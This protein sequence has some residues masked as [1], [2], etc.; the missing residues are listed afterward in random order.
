MCSILYLCCLENFSNVNNQCNQVYSLYKWSNPH[1]MI[2]WCRQSNF[3]CVILCLMELDLPEVVFS[4]RT[5]IKA[6]YNPHQ[7][8]TQCYTQTIPPS[9][10]CHIWSFLSTLNT[11]EQK[12]NVLIMWTPPLP[13]LSSTLSSWPE[14][15]SLLINSQRPPFEAQLPCLTA[16]LRHSLRGKW[17]YKK[18]WSIDCQLNA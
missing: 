1:V 8:Y 18:K 4:G 3:L 2:P 7:A 14:L 10:L 16:A 9:T 5:Y 12:F 15:T 17:R 11:G 13:F 6:A